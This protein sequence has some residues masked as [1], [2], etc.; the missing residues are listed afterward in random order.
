MDCFR[1]PRNKMD[2]VN[3]HATIQQIIINTVTLALNELFHLIE[4]DFPQN[5][6]SSK[7]T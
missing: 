4:I 7:T 3:P 6:N 2:S 5:R 1:E